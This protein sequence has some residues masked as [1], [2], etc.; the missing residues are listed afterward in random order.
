MVWRARLAVASLWVSQTARVLAD[1]A[2]RIFVV[3]ELYRAGSWQPD[4]AWQL[5][6][7]L[8]MLP[9]VVLAPVNGTL[10]NSLPKPLVLWTSAAYCLGVVAVFGWLRGP[11]LAAWA[12]IA[13]GAAV[14]GPTRYAL[15]PAAARDA[16]LP[17]TR[18]NGWIE[19]GSA[20]AIIA[21][22]L[23]GADWHGD[24]WGDWDAVLVIAGALN[25]LAVVTALPVGFPSDIRRRERAGQAI[26]GFFH[27]C[28]RV[29]RDPQARGAL[30]G[31]A[32]LRALITA[33]MGAVIG[34]ALG[35]RTVTI[36]DVL[37]VYLP[38]AAWIVGGVA[39]GSVLAGLQRHPRRALGLVPFGA[40]GLAIGL[41]IAAASAVPGPVLCVL[42][43]SMWGL[44][45]VP[46][47]ATYQAALPVDARGNGMAVRN[48]A[49]YLAIAVTSLFMF[50]LAREGIV[51]PQGQLWLAAVVALLGA[52]V[53]WWLLLLVALEQVVEILIWPMYRIRARGPGLEQIPPR[54]PL[55]VIANHSSWFDPVWVAKL[56]PRRVIPMMTSVFYDLPGLKPLM[57]LAEVIRVQAAT[58]RRD[59]PEIRQ[60]VAAL[61]RGECLLLFP[62]GWMRRREDVPL[63]L[64]GQGI[65]LIL[66]ER[67]QT[68]VVVCW[69]EGGWGSYFSHR[70]GPPTKN[71][72]FDWWRHI[73][74][75]M[76]LPRLIEPALIDDQ[77]ALR[78]HLMQACLQAR[79]HLGLEPFAFDRA[80][81]LTD[82]SVP[83]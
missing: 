32:A 40:L 36:S 78:A 80:A 56:I 65:A 52:V 74:I 34:V 8:L 82:E 83:G 77:R 51:P 17:L 14:Y 75:A 39:L 1:C 76:E 62:E 24:R 6:T 18:L 47:A 37:E 5:V 58:Y 59:V 43:G 66:K 48:F 4:A 41:I 71:K 10:S 16:K 70:G 69:I 13:L 38:I 57:R 28:R 55:L 26:A 73:D 61:D 49:D 68:A 54:G 9:A 19:A 53:S 22:F 31:L 63:R 21:G 23:L 20:V 72:R 44:I 15:L 12:L 64:F 67:P 3:L 11:W 60:A 46:L 30:L 45:N 79:R 50:G 35:D 33:I 42:L 27:D 25:L 2:L 29:W 7:V 81:E